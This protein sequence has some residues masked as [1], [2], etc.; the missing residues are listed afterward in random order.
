MAYGLASTWMAKNNGKSFG[1]IAIKFSRG[2][3]KLLE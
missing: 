1:K 2:N 3:G